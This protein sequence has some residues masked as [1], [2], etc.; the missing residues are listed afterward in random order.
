MFGAILSGISAVTGL[1]GANKAAKAQS[2]ANAAA[3]GE[4]RR[5]FDLTRADLAPGRES[6]NLAHGRL[7]DIYGGD[8]IDG[9]T[10]LEQ[11][12]EYK[13]NIEQGEKA[14]NRAAAAGGRRLSPAVL[15]ELIRY[16]KGVNTSAYDRYMNNIYRLAGQGGASVS[17]GVQA[18][19][20]TANAIAGLNV[21]QGQNQANM[22]A[23]YNNIIQGSL[24]NF[25]TLRSY[26][27][28]LGSIGQSGG[29]YG[30]AA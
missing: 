22:Y 26:N 8:G 7:Q 2:K 30:E 23:N 11:S 25:Q 10:I 12:P 4:Q 24:G 14:I 20:N 21:Q 27:K 5:Q 13:F 18:G 29:I 3:I 16:N 17:Q 19:Q 9:Q 15:Q 1:I 28:G 6:Y